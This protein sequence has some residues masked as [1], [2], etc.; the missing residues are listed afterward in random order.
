MPK[1]ILNTNR[2]FAL[3]ELVVVMVL[4]GIISVTLLKSFSQILI[5]VDVP[6]KL[7]KTSNL[8]TARMN[9]ILASRANTLATSVTDPCAS[10]PPAACTELASYASNNGLSVL[11]NLSTNNDERTITVDV[12]GDGA[13][14]VYTKVENF[15]TA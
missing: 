6:L 8:A 3:F 2:G 7:L 11:S 13:T 1:K 4:I 9:L 15:E 10:S 5:A 12:T 14:S